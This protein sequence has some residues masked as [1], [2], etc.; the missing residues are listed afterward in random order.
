MPRTPWWVDTLI[1][2]Q[3]A[4]AGISNPNLMGPFITNVID[5]RGLTCTR[6]LIHLAFMTTTEGGSEGINAIDCG[7]GVINNDAFVDGSFPDVNAEEDRP[8][9]GWLWRDR[10]I[11]RETIQGT[12]LVSPGYFTEVKADIRS[13]R[14][15]DSGVLWLSMVN[16]TLAG[17]GHATQI[18]GIVRALMLLP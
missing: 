5:R 11:T 8:A 6:L 9:R 18:A 1:A 17:S 3:L 13:R 14:R 2:T 15:I 7:I 4:A 12:N 10:Y 16:T